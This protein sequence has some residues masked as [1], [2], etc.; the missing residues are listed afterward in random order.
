M[1]GG[2]LGD[3]EA[4]V[5][6]AAEGAASPGGSQAAG[7]MWMKD[8]YR[9]ALDKARA[10]GKM[11]FV[12]FTGYSCANC[13]WM[14]AN[15][16]SRPEISALL[17]KFVLVELYTD[18]TD[19]ASEANAKLEADKFKTVSQPFYVILQPDETVVATFDHL[20]RDPAEFQAFLEKTGAP[21]GAGSSSPSIVSK[22]TTLQGKPLDPAAFTGKV[23]VVDFWATYCGPCI[24][25]IPSFNKIHQDFAN[26]GVA[27]L[28]VG[29]DEEGA[30]L[31]VPFLKKHP[32]DYP[33]ALGSPAVN[34]E[35]NLEGLPVTLVI[36]RTGKQVKRFDGLTPEDELRA[37]VEQA[38][39]P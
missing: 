35:Y 13:H 27:V 28:G 18:G 5:P 26:R 32:M 34:K 19:A 7:L 2:N 4:Y 24:K 16:L 17:G 33:V 6:A 25:E 12:D 14:R 31:V 10:E 21:A 38:A 22:F 20:T 39:R 37:A 15:I 29:M 30:E 23:I 1:F 11:V 3:L 36:D 9:A 8:Q